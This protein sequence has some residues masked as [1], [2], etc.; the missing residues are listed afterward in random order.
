MFSGMR[1]TV[2][3]IFRQVYAPHVVFSPYNI[4]DLICCGAVSNGAAFCAEKF[5]WGDQGTN[6]GTE[7]KPPLFLS[8]VY[9][10]L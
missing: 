9:S 4:L 6:T 7:K 3:P 5:L 2:L 10:L 8:G 1:F